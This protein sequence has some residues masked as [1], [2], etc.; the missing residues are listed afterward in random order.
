MKLKN[1][2]SVDGGFILIYKIMSL[3]LKFLDFLK[4]IT[5]RNS[6]CGKVMFSQVSVCPQLGVCMAGGVCM[7]RGV[8]MAG[9]HVWWGACL[10]GGMHWG[11]A[12][13]RH[14][15]WGCAWQGHAW[16]GLCVAGGPA[17][18]RG[19]VWQWVCVAEETATS[20]DGTHPT[21]MH[22]CIIS[23]FRIQCV[24]TTR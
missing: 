11:H 1:M 8:Y 3:F 17:W 10:A 7:A 14:A 19:C 5:V 6:S 4:L 13:Q 22:S 23:N 9:G 15:W 18:P 2:W 12:W 16:Q 24:R 21:G 20:A